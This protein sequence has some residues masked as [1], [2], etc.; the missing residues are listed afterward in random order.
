MLC[1]KLLTIHLNKYKLVVNGKALRPS[2]SLLLP[3]C[4]THPPTT[5]S[6]Y[7]LSRTQKPTCHVH[8]HSSTSPASPF[9]LLCTGV[10]S[11]ESS[12]SAFFASVF[13]KIELPT[14]LLMHAFFALW[15]GRG[16]WIGNGANGGFWVR[17]FGV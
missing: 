2:L 7:K 9:L 12:A 8:P 13:M 10:F 6:L 1:Q 3:P 5:I 14:R 15:V 17:I 11:C 16:E 4:F